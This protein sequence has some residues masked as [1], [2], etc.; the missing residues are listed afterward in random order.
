MKIPVKSIKSLAVVAGISLVAL[1]A[2]AATGHLPLARKPAISTAGADSGPQ[3]IMVTAARVRTA[4]FI[5]S[6][7]V[8]GSLVPREE[9]LVGPEVEG[10]RVV[11]VLAD[12]GDR[13]KK[14]QTLARLVSDTLEAQLGQNTASLAKSVAG[15]A[16]AQSNIA[17]VEAKLVEARGAYNRGKPLTKSGYLSESVM[18]S[19]EAAAKSA[20][21][22]VASA[23]DGLKVAEAD[24]AQVEAQ[25]REI[26][27]RRGRTE[28]VSPADGIVS[29]RMA[30]IGGYASGVA[31]AMFRVIANGEIE[32]DAE[33]TEN[34]ISKLREGLPVEVSVAGGTAVSGKIRLVS[35]EIDK[36]TRLGKVRVFLGDNPAL[37]IGGF[38][39]GVIETAKSRGLAVPAA[40]LLY[41]ADG[42]SVQVV[43]EGTVRTRRVKLGLEQGQLVEVREGLAEGDIVVAKSG[44]FL[45]DGDLVR[46]VITSEKRR[47]SDASS[48]G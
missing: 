43:T 15:I 40:S 36:A 3:P 32:L 9:I 16:Q 23:R 37:H 31:D 10:L 12:E 45:R 29:R 1:G 35:P 11:E 4:D 28:V 47:T 21:A 27:W 48:A 25:R 41:G 19:R 18:E 13:V 17:S 30:R 38:A 2:L 8:T 14:G 20:E 22:A 34:R 26:V 33:V 42:V 46:A 7:V 39:R 24:K 6:V 44:T 5:E